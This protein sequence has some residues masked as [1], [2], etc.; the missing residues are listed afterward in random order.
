MLQADLLKYNTS[1]ILRKGNSLSILLQL[2]KETGS[3]AVYWN[4]CYE[5]EAI[6]RD[7]QIQ[8]HLEGEGI[9]V[10]S[11]GA[12]L[13]FEPWNIRNQSGSYFKVFT[14]FW[15]HCLAAHQPR[16]LSPIPHIQPYDIFPQSD[17]I[18]TW[19]LI[20]Q[21][22]NWSEKFTAYWQPGER[23]GHDVLAAFVAN[24]MD[25]YAIGRDIPSV[26][27][28]SRL[29]PYLHFGEVSPHQVWYK[30][31]EFCERNPLCADAERYTDRE[32]KSEILWVT[33]L[34][35]DNFKSGY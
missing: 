5:P 26:K 12:N 13:L 16:P 29:S 8:Q 21:H 24:T 15:K 27:G 22:P 17:D 14:P 32:R 4:T 23:N 7:T 19:N 1:L 10:H 20:P 6:A 18:A 9:A 31:K 3:H 25:G 28:T 2:A 30:V 33:P 35:G 34:P 11:F